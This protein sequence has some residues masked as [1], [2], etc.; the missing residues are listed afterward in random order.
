VEPTQIIPTVVDIPS[1]LELSSN[2]VCTY[3]KE[4]RQRD[5]ELGVF[6]GHI[7]KRAKRSETATG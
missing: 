2:Q 6:G 7:L 4:F 3:L 1:K 5:D